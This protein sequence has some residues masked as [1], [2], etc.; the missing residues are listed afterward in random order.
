MDV[1]VLVLLILTIAVGLLF[2]LRGNKMLRILVA[3]YAFWMGASRLYEL[4]TAYAPTLGTGW[5]WGISLAAGIL[6]AILALVFIKF[7]IF[8]AGG[9]LGVALYRMVAALNPVYFG[10]LS[11]LMSF[12]IGLIF[13]VALGFIALWAKD[14]LLIVATAGWGAYTA[15]LGAGILIG[16][17]LHP[18]RLPAAVNLGSLSGYSIFAAVPAALPI[19]ITVVLGIVGIIYQYRH[20]RKD[21]RRR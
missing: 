6:L 13:F 16:L 14:F 19:T 15:V 3:V 10:S 1:T 5:S 18:V 2:C 12:L 11:P 21:Q 20:P 4:L 8:V 17:L 7:T 9:L